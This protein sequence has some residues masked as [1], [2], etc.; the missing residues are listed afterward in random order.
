MHDPQVVRPRDPA[1]HLDH[2]GDHSPGRQR[3]G[4]E[5]VGERL[6]VEQLHHHEGRPLRRLTVV[7]DFDHVRVG[8]QLR[9]LRLSPEALA[10]RLVGGQHPAQHFDRARPLETS[11]PRP[12]DRRHPPLADDLLDD[13]PAGDRR[14][15]ERVA[16]LR[17]LRAVEKAKQRVLGEAQMTLRAR[18]HR[19]LPRAG[20]GKTEAHPIPDVCASA[21]Q[22][23]PRRGA[24]RT[25]GVKCSPKCHDGAA[26]VR[27]VVLEED[28]RNLGRWMSARLA[29]AGLLLVGAVLAGRVLLDRWW[30]LLLRPVDGAALPGLKIDGVALAAGALVR[31]RVEEQIEALRSRPVRLV[32]RDGGEQGTDH[33]VLETTL[34]ALGVTVDDEDVAQRALRVG[35]TEDFATR[36]RLADRARAGALDVPLQ[37]RIDAHVALAQLRTLKE[38]LDRP[39]VSARLDVQHHAVVPERDGRALDVAATLA[40]VGRIARDAGAVDVDLPFLAV[41]PPRVTTLSLEGVDVSHVLATFTTYFSRRG[42]QEPRA[43][44]I[45]VA[46]SHVDGL[47]LEPG[48]LV[49]FNDLVGARSEDNGFQKAFEIYK[50]EMVEGTGG[51]TCQVASTLH[52]IAFFGGLDIVQRLPHSRPSPYIP[53]GLDATVVYPVV[54][55]KL[56]NPYTFPVVVRAD[57]GNNTLTMQLLGAQKTERVALMRTVLE[58]TP[59]ERKVIED[60]ALDKPKRKQKGLDGITLLRKRFIVLADGQS[61]VETSR[62]KY[63]PTTEIW[64]VPP[65]YD[66]TELPPLGEDFPNPEHPDQPP[67][68]AHVNDPEQ[69]IWG[70]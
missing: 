61:K 46:A 19:G 57:V 34:G 67:P 56:R 35:R 26:H 42:D 62:D 66:E 44:N 33:A 3:A 27:S 13:V 69:T 23:F 63:P 47:V 32:V 36:A 70:G 15:D 20:G 58:T 50:G 43:R 29:V 59:F 14:A 2:V 68:A 24:R 22:A 25:N 17:Q 16:D 21:P 5:H 38:E 64:K 45:D 6:P 9:I 53:V 48:D 51:G 40:A 28:D 54:D 12:V 55:L 11:L 18:L 49:S 1:G 37:P 60:P 30:P 41:P 65:G 7:V 8:E 31:P 10:D 39:A 52:A 4:T